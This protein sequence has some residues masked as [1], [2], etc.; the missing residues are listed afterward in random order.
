MVNVSAGVFEYE[1]WIGILPNVE[2]DIGPEVN[3]ERSLDYH[4]N[5]LIFNEEEDLD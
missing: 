5:E 2:A 1:K 3:P 4:L